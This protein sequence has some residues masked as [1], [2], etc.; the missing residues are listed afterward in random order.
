MS[1]LHSSRL[2][3]LAKVLLFALIVFSCNVLSPSQ[4]GNMQATAECQAFH[5][6]Q[7]I[8]EHNA[9]IRVGS[10][11]PHWEAFTVVLHAWGHG[12]DKISSAP[13]QPLLAWLPG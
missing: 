2:L 1:R 6:V 10:R 3:L 5:L 7:F 8:G 4:T 13:A 12:E 9:Y 11:N